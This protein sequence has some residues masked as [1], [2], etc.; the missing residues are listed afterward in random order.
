[1]DSDCET[2]ADTV[3]ERL[4]DLGPRNTLSMVLE[5]RLRGGVCLVRSLTVAEGSKLVL[6]PGM[7]RCPEADHDDP[8]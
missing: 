3:S 5:R 4:W 2:E 7:R 1:M 8:W 6:R